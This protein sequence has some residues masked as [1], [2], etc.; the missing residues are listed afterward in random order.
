MHR[1]RERE[2]ERFFICL[3]SVDART[4]VSENTLALREESAVVGR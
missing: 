1:E 4:M 3:G 2:R